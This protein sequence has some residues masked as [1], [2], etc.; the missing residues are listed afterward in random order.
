M[1]FYLEKYLE[2]RNFIECLDWILYI[3]ILDCLL[4][5]SI[6]YFLNFF[7]SYIFKENVYDFFFE[8]LS[9]FYGLDFSS[10]FYDLTFLG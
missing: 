8:E 3:T 7:I 1:I 4:E 10:V 5:L 9:I 6:S 2:V